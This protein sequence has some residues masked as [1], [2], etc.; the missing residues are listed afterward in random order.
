M[1]IIKWLIQYCEADVVGK[2]RHSRLA[3]PFHYGTCFLL[4]SIHS[5]CSSFSLQHS[6]FAE[7]LFF[8]IIV[9]NRLF[10]PSIFPLIETPLTAV[11][12]YTWWSHIVSWTIIVHFLHLYFYL[13]SHLPIIHLFQVAH[14]R[15]HILCKPLFNHSLSCCFFCL[16]FSFRWD[17]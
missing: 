14:F 9:R 2:N 6:L 5:S 12:N 11:K 13:L 16:F 4:N 1:F 17:F 10:I 15:S 3:S 8:L 7:I